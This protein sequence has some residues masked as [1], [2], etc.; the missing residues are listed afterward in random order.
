MKDEVN[1]PSVLC[2]HPS[3]L[4]PSSFACATCHN[5]RT[6]SPIENIYW[7]YLIT[8]L[9]G[10]LLYGREV[11]K[12]QWFND[13]ATRKREYQPIARPSPRRSQALQLLLRGLSLKQIAREMHVKFVTAFKHL[14]DLLKQENVPNRAALA[15]KFGSTAPQP[16]D[17]HEQAAIRRARV[18]EL[19]AMG[20]SN[21]QIAIEVGASYDV[22]IKDMQLLSRQH[23]VRGRRQLI[24]KLSACRLQ[25]ACLSVENMQAQDCTPNQTLGTANAA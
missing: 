6:V 1:T 24:E 18:I 4:S 22:I 17:P 16:P 25:P 15:R 11:P 19:L 7:N 2:P 14:S 12:P 3:A 13:F 23:R 21:R 20:L 5:I 9:S 8:H 10:G